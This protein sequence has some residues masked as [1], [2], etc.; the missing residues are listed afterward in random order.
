MAEPARQ[1][2]AAD[3][4]VPLRSERFGNYDVPANRVLH[5]AAG[6]IGFPAARRFALLD[7]S[8][9][10]SPFRCLVCLDLPEL[11][12]VVCDPLRLWPDYAADVPALPEARPE[13]VAVLA[14]VTL[15]RDP[16]EMTANLLAPLVLD[17]RSRAGAQV[18]LDTGRYGTRHPLLAPAAE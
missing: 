14:I 18:V 13:D 1:E 16:R 3:A 15:P 17:S 4:T 9:P 11:G 12:F 10:E 2:L 6:L 5:F 8:R 7:S